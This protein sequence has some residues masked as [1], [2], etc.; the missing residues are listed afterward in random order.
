MI[1]IIHFLGHFIQRVIFKYLQM[2]I[3]IF[4]F[5]F[6]VLFKLL[7]YFFELNVVYFEFKKK[8]FFVFIFDQFKHSQI[9]FYILNHFIWNFVLISNFYNKRVIGRLRIFDFFLIL[10]NLYFKIKR[11]F[12]TFFGRVVVSF[13][14]QMVIHYKFNFFF[15][16]I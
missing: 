3:E 11:E 5:V 9:L 6:K 14:C 13:Y 1:K 16:M 12:V 8:N 10:Y 15:N 2:Y 4:H 7:V